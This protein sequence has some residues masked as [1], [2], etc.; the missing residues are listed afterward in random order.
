MNRLA[1]AVLHRLSPIAVNRAATNA[2]WYYG[3][4]II[5]TENIGMV[6]QTTDNVAV[7]TEAGR[8]TAT[9]AAPRVPLPTG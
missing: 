4:A 1:V 8:K 5:V 9:A 2:I 6:A 7:K 3:A